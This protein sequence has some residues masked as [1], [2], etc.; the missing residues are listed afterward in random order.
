MPMKSRFFEVFRRRTLFRI[1][2]GRHR[3]SRRGKWGG[4]WATCGPGLPFALCLVAQ[5]AFRRLPFACRRSLSDAGHAAPNGLMTE[6]EQKGAPGA[7][8]CGGMPSPFPVLSSRAAEGRRAESWVVPCGEYSSTLRQVLEYSPQST[9][10]HS[11]R[12]G[13]ASGRGGRRL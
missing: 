4:R 5:T 12:R 7:S 13:V 6:S 9:L 3:G 8:P 11:A 1:C 10:A 2:R